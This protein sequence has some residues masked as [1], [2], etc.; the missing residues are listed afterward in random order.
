M[1]W[2]VEDASQISEIIEMAWCDKTSFEDIYAITGLS[3]REIINIMR[4]ALKTSSFRKW[5][6]RTRGRK[7]KHRQAY[8]TRLRGCR[9]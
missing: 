4:T 2:Q 5:R 1:T 9:S 3:E 8:L 7:T 6:A